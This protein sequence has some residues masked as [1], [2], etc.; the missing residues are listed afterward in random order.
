VV[1][2]STSPKVV[3]ELV[4]QRLPGDERL[5]QIL[6]RKEVWIVEGHATCLTQ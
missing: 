5:E 2:P 6:P 1:L 4:E 3:E